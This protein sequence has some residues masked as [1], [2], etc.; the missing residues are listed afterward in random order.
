MKPMTTFSRMLRAAV[1]AALLALPFASAAQAGGKDLIAT[2]DKKQMT[3]LMNNQGY[4]VSNGEDGDIVWQLEGYKVL[5]LVDKSGESL[6]LRASFGKT[7]TTIN[8]VNQW[9][10]QMRYSRSFLDGDGDPV[11]ELDLD[12]AGGISRERIIDYLA[13]CKTSFVAWE[14]SVIK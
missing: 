10:Q 3:E 6:L 12:L 9:N 7:A 5:L 4:S 11:L 1:L 13:T 2:I 8:D 14:G